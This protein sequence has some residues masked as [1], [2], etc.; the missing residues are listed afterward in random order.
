MEAKLTVD[1]LTLSEPCPVQSAN[2]PLMRCE[3]SFN[4][5]IVTG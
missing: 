4:W 5:R 3:R 2:G 1:S